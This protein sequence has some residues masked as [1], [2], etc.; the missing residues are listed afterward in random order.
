MMDK[1]LMCVMSEQRP[2]ASLPLVC[3]ILLNALCMF[4]YMA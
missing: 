1:L 4:S 3:L 2:E